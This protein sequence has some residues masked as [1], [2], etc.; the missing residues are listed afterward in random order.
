MESDLYCVLQERFNS[1][2]V[3]LMNCAGYGASDELSE[4]STVRTSEVAWS[5]LSGGS[6]KGRCSWLN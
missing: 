2:R 1:R 3:S 6:S 4:G 5:G